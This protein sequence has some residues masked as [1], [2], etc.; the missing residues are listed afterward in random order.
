MYPFKNR[1][2]LTGF[3]FVLMIVLMACGE[4]GASSNSNDDPTPSE[5]A[6]ASE[7]PMTLTVASLNNYP[8]Q[9][10]KQDGELTGFEYDLLKAVAEEVD[11]DLKFQEMKFEAFIPSLQGGQA[12]VA[13]SATITEERREVIDYSDIFLESGMVL[14]VTTDSPIQSYEDLKGKTIA[15]TAGSGSATFIKATELAEEYD[16]EV[17]GLKETDM[18]FKDVEIGNADALVM[19][20]PTAAY[21]IQI[22]GDHPKFRVV[23][24][25]LTVDEHAF[26]VKKGNTEVLEK[27][28]EGLKKVRDNGK[29]D[30]IHK[31]WYGE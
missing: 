20:S 2:L 6:E 27:L 1:F 10:F 29:Y 21:R 8:P 17:K 5:S 24:D 23:G 18:V 14:V 7:V 25:H 12:D 19:N 13:T 9:F 11:I 26:S 16:A 30:E 31:A 15:A 3:I 4:K 22:D 28:N